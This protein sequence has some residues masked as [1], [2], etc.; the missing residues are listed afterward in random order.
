MLTLYAA[1]AL[2]GIITG[3]I[4]WGQIRWTIGRAGD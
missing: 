2:A 1:R 4:H 3:W